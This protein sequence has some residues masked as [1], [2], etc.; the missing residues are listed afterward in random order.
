MFNRNE[1]INS[2]KYLIAKALAESLNLKSSLLLRKIYEDFFDVI[3]IIYF[4]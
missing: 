4:T 3:T 1:I 2:V